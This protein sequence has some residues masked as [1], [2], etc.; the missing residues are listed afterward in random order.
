MAKPEPQPHKNSPYASLSEEARN[1]ADPRLQDLAATTQHAVLHPTSTNRTLSHQ[2]VL[3]AS[4][5]KSLPA[6]DTSTPACAIV[7]KQ[8]RR[9]VPALGTSCG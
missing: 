6:N 4:T 1:L 7:N 3:S 8:H 2:W 9:V 5:N